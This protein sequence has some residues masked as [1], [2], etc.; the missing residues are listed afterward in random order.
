MENNIYI[1][2]KILNNNVILTR[3]IKE[4]SNYILMGK[5]LG[6]NKKIGEEVNIQKKDI[7]KSFHNFDDKF[8]NEFI[9]TINNFNKDII[10][11]SNRIIK[12]AEQKL[13]Q[14][15]SHIFMTL[16]DHI[17][18][19]IER[20]KTNIDIDNPFLKQIKMLLIDEYKVAK[21]ASKLIEGKFNIII[22]EE[23]IGFIAFHLNAAKENTCVKN[24]VK[25]MR[26]F[27]E[28]VFVLEKEINVKSKGN[29]Y[30]KLL[31]Y[32]QNII[33]GKENEYEDM[34]SYLE[35]EIENK[36]PKEYNISCKICKL[37]E[38][39]ADI[40]ISQTKIALL[41]MCIKENAR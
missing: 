35:I 40:K 18:F 25:D 28:V 1:V 37:I 34:V 41:T 4:N 7:E 9:E 6:F 30:H 16:T 31:N 13:G 22:P 5:G 38:E 33:E 12:M 32:I 17:S 23:E 20:L 39:K 26:I 36:F 2:E 21:E 29:K 27:K 19:A 10:E 11:V 15:N 24:V 8:K 3:K 14:L